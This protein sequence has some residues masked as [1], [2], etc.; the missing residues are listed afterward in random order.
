MKTGFRS[1]VQGLRA[2]AVGLVVA[3]HLAT[4]QLAHTHHLAGGFIGVDVFFVL[5]GYLITQLILREVDR[6][7][8]V[9]LSD[10]YARRARRILPAATLVLL[11]VLAFSAVRVP[12]A[13]LG[14]TVSDS[15]WSAFFF[16][17]WHFAHIGTSYFH[18][19]SLSP[20]QHYWSL[21]V[22]EQFYLVWP[23]LML[24]LAPR[25]R[26]R[27][28]LMVIGTIAAASLAWSVHTTLYAGQAGRAAAY[29]STP[30]RAYELA[31]GA[32]LAAA[33]MP[34]LPRW[35]RLVLGLGGLG[36]LVW[37]TVGFRAGAAFPGWEALVPTL[38]TA[39]L[40]VAGQGSPTVVTRMLAMRPMRH[41]G[42]ISYSVYLWHFPVIVL[43]P[44][45]L[46]VAWP[47][48]VRVGIE[49]VLIL[50][51][52]AASY[53]L[54]E[55]PFQ[56]RR[57][58]L[59]STGRRGLV[60]WPAALLLVLAGTSV[61]TG[62]AHHLQHQ[63]AEAAAAW[64]AAH[65]QQAAVTEPATDSKT[66]QGSGGGR[67]ADRAVVPVPDVAG[68]L[69][70]AVQ[71]AEQGA[72][73][74]PGLSTAQLSADGW[75]T[76][77]HC[78]ASETVNR[79]PHPP[80]SP[81]CV[82]GDPSAHRT[83]AVVGDSHAGMW[84][85]ALG[86]IAAAEHLRLVPFIKVSCSPY[87]V[88]QFNVLTP[89]ATC[90]DYRAW[91]LRQLRRLKPDGIIVAARG[92]L[93]MGPPGTASVD[94][95]WQSG[96]TQVLTEFKQITPHL[97][98]LGDILGRGSQPADCLTQPGYREL[99]CLRP[100]SSIETHSNAVTAAV[101][102]SLGA[103][104]IR[105]LPLVCTPRECPLLVGTTVLYRDDSHVTRTWVLHVLPLLASLL[106]APLAAVASSGR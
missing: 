30:A 33:P 85:P 97:I 8:R 96:M 60:L 28:L 94:E 90:A 69:S 77:F 84:L 87:A 72:P 35:S 81:Q 46:P 47:S 24:L 51:L 44:F 98:V 95:Q 2:I 103:S 71:L 58:H 25:V 88:T 29:F 62:Y 5:S 20:L 41:L 52:S 57:V 100:P 39:V 82:L 104:Y 6:T 67:S 27:T 105:T 12:T 48:G 36:A 106:H 86:P 37:A 66:G 64:W 73:F 4:Y 53:R 55:Q 79:P 63:R 54:V 23:L 78:Y 11:A 13:R 42:D 38:A 102:Q 59:V 83:L 50:G 1:D 75:Q 7:G 80:T 21:S 76:T 31:L 18:T 101:A 99:D 43:A 61:A 74:P 65:P 26:R 68:E 10:F 34:V 93:Y 92:E 9:S 40:L 15:W 91:T 17:N 70:A 14:Q 45:Y 22:E 56:Q 89:A 19:T 3:A 49:L 16:A 32:L